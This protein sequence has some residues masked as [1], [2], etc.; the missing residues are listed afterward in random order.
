MKLI[1]GIKK[2]LKMRGNMALKNKYT[3][4]IMFYFIICMTIIQVSTF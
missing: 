1:E 2:E 3:M 4:L